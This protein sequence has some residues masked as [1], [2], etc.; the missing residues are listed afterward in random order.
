MFLMEI[1][2]NEPAAAPIAGHLWS[3]VAEVIL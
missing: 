2:M 3:D 1:L